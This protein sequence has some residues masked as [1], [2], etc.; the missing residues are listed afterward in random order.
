M[1]DEREMEGRGE[2]G[3]AGLVC[4]SR[5]EGG[6]FEVETRSGWGQDVMRWDG[7]AAL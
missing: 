5:I 1:M 4:S 6:V 3:D 7:R 2:Q